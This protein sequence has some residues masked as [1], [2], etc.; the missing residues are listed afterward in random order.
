[1]PG[2]KMSR[3]LGNTAARRTAAGLGPAH[4]RRL[5]WPSRAGGGIRAAPVPQ[6]IRGSLQATLNPCAYNTKWD[7]GS[8]AEPGLLV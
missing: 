2:A 8:A 5:R 7:H 1:M 4:P 3:V 6:P